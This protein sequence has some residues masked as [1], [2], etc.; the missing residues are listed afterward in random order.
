M[1][2]RGR[3]IALAMLASAAIAQHAVAAPPSGY[4]SHDA[5]SASLRDAVDDVLLSDGSPVY[6]GRDAQSTGIS[7][8]ADQ[9]TADRFQFQPWRSRRARIQSPSINGGQP[10][11]CEFTRV[12]FT[13]RSIPNWYEKITGG[14][15]SSVPSDAFFQ[16]N[17]DSVGGG[18]TRWVVA[19]PDDSDECTLIERLDAVTW[20]F[21]APGYAP[22]TETEPATGCPARLITRVK[23]KGKT[24]TTEQ[25]GLSAPMQITAVIP[26]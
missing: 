20:R 2:T 21:T 15:R 14:E 3:A 1:K 6:A 18:E 12:V 22:A 19:Y 5:A 13:S 17:P 23:S 10:V 25:T 16:C 8:A 26:S 9:L 24:T 11:T 4:T 7:D